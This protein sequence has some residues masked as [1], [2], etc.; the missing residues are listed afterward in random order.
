[1]NK[2][3]TIALSLLLGMS[4]AS[5]VDILDENV[6]GDRAHSTTLAQQLPVLVFYAQQ[7]V[8]DHAE[9]HIYLSQCLTTT[10]KSQTGSYP[11]KQGWE[12]LNINRHPQ[13]RRH[14]F[15][16]G[17]N[18][19]DVISNARNE[20]NNQK[21]GKSP[22]YEFIARAIRL[23][24]AQ[25]TTDAF[26]PMPL[27]PEAGGD[28]YMSNTP[29]YEDQ[30]AIYKWMF[31]EADYLI[32]NFESFNVENPS[33][34]IDVKQDRVY[35]GDIRKWLGL[36]HATKARLL[37]RNIPN[38]DRSQAMC[39]SI[40]DA[41]QDAIDIWRE[42][43]TYGW[44]GSEPR[45]KFD[46]G[47]GTQ[48]SPWSADQPKINSWE[49][50]D[51][52]LNS[53]VPSKYFMYD[54]LGVIEHGSE[55]AQGK[56]NNKFGA[57]YGT[58]PRIMLLMVPQNG[59]TSVADA[60]E[61]VA[62][63]YLENNIG[64]GASI[65]QAHYPVLYAGAYAAGVDAYNPIFTM[66][67]LYFIQAEAYYW[68]GERATAL[69]LVK[70]ATENNILRH[71]E[72]FKADNQ[73]HCPGNGCK[74]AMTGDKINESIAAGDD[75]RFMAAIQCF[76][77]NTEV[78]YE[79]YEFNKD[80]T[81][82]EKPTKKTM[83]SLVT[84]WGNGHWF[85]NPDKFSLSD[86][87]QQKYIAMY[88]QPEQWTDMRRYHYS[89]KRNNIGI[90]PNAEIVYPELR[91]PYNLYQAYWVDNLTQEDQEKT[92]IQRLNYD[93]QTE[94]VYNRNEVIR[95]GAFKDFKW[96]M[97]PMIWAEPEGARTSLTK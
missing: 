51:N 19:N 33:Q 14:F 70:E 73:G 10:G 29:R 52:M 47:T 6:N 92:W 11:Y 44:F 64:S 12:F 5:C 94:D 26:G 74:V 37:L 60:T 15:D 20:F 38:V 80:G 57:G 68:K 43:A 88:M 41:A 45:Y 4:M 90:G 81:K 48:N 46:G 24:S 16:I 87:M 17:V 32:N 23:M 69:A 21:G 61:I 62:M 59:P 35:A 27:H 95:V 76:L 67:E 75:A 56:Y 18:G 91:R 89:N 7:T 58:D 63:R 97:K 77:N 2:F 50:R 65:K 53:A 82:K 54:L 78:A 66:E 86:L 40:I 22:K 13:W 85:F 96:L 1:M 93:P 55:T 39:Q 30:T 25:M 36:V 79:Y 49:S 31:E 3:K 83:T 34:K 9:Y 71:L 28:A 84:D 42:D 8:Y 72:R